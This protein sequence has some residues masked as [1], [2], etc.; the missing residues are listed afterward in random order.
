VPAVHEYT[1]FEH[2]ARLA[3]EL[4]EAKTR[5][6]AL[7]AKLDRQRTQKNARNSRWAKS[8]REQV[9]RYQTPYMREYRARKRGDDSG[10][11][12]S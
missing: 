12:G 10:S 7:E 11:T 3:D 1:I 9:N 4:L 8:H 6:A 5:L 2:T